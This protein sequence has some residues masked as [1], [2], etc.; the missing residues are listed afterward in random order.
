MTVLLIPSY[1]KIGNGS[2]EKQSAECPEEDR[3]G[4]AAADEAGGDVV[5]LAPDRDERGAVDSLLVQDERES[6]ACAEV[7]A[8]DG[9]GQRGE[10]EKNKC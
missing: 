8:D 3:A 6:D 7:I 1:D 4:R 9:N 5:N 2:N 10:E